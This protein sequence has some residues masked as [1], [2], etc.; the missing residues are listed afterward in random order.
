MIVRM[1]T[2]R[3]MATVGVT[4]VMLALVVAAC[5]SDSATTTRP[6]EGA[7][8]VAAAPASTT[9]PS[10]GVRL[11]ATTR[12]T[13]DQT[14][15]EAFTKS[16]EPGMAASVWIGG[17]RWDGV[18]GV[19]DLTTKT[20]FRLDDYV[21]IASISK[22]FTATAVLQLVDQKKLSLDDKLEKYVPGIANGTEITV[23]QLLNMSSGIYDFTADENFLAAFNADPAMAWKP[24]QVLDIVK[25]HE[26]DFAP[27]AKTVYC[28]TNYILLGMITEKVTGR[29]AEDVINQDVV[30]KVGLKNTSFP[31]AFTVPE[32]HPTAYLP[33][34]DKPTEPPKVVNDVNPAVA[35][36]A[37][38]MISTVDDLKLWG[39][40]LA[41][42]TL[43]S[44][45][46]QSERLI[47]HQ[48]DG[49]QLP[50]GYGLGIAKV[51]PFLGHNGAILGY[52][53]VVLRDP[54]ADA[55]FVAVGNSSTN[56][57]GQA[58]DVVLQMIQKLYPDALK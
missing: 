16:G 47:S 42:G 52:T 56:S 43:L 12:A 32:P 10:A 30:A 6:T 13:L 23:R 48:W 25:R 18:K 55:T 41:K 34:P 20:S 37:G 11:D 28:D 19:S 36:T 9:A 29:T 33:N 46:L 38:A 14:F 35:W 54:E 1:A 58:T 39:D 50:A 57:T 5:G 27:G 53:S 8:T 51:G 40:E 21:R 2:P 7:T 49:V 44:P 22:S 3:R 4:C 31:T 26:P 17:E 15:A 24:A 45:E